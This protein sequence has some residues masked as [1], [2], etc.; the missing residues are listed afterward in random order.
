[1]AE[2]TAIPPEVTGA[3]VSRASAIR[4]D[5]ETYARLVR[6]RSGRT[7]FITR[8][9]RSIY[10]LR[11]STP[12]K[13][14]QSTITHLRDELTKYVDGFNDANRQIESHLED[15]E[16]SLM[17]D[18]D[19]IDEQL[20]R[21]AHLF[22]EV[23]RLQQR[24]HVWKTLSG[25]DATTNVLHDSA[26]K[27]SSLFRDLLCSFRAELL[28]LQ[29]TYCSVLE[30]PFIQDRIKH[31]T[32]EISAFTSMWTDAT[33]S[34]ATSSPATPVTTPSSSEPR[35]R[36][37][38]INVQIKKFKGNPLKW[39][40]Y[41][42]AIKSTLND[43]A[44]GFSECS[45][46]TIIQDSIAHPRAESIVDAKVHEG[47]SSEEIL[48][49][50][51]YEFGREQ[52][53]L[54][55]LVA[56]IFNVPQLAKSEASVL[57]FK[58][59]VLTPYVVLR[60][61]VDRDMDLVFPHIFQSYMTPNMRQMW[62]QY[63]DDKLERPTVD[64]LSKFLDTRFKWTRPSLQDAPS[65]SPAHPHQPPVQFK[66]SVTPPQKK[67]A[68]SNKCVLCDE[69]HW[70]G[71]CSAFAALPLDERNQLVRQKRLCLNCLTP[72]HAVKNC[73]NKHTCRHCGQKHHS[74]LHRGSQAPT[75]PPATSAVA[76]AAPTST[77]AQ[78]TPDL[79]TPQTSSPHTSFICSVMTRLEFQGAHTRA[80]LQMD[81][82][83]GMNFITED[84]ASLLKL[85]RYPQELSFTGVGLGTHRSTSY[86]L[87]PIHSCNSSFKTDPVRLSIVPK[88]VTTA[89]PANAKEV[90]ARA[91]QAGI[92]L[93]DP[94]LDG[95]VDLLVGGDYPWEFC[96]DSKV[97]A[98]YRFISTPFG[99][100]AVGPMLGSPVSLAT[101]AV[102]SS[103]S[104]DLSKLWTLDQVP[105]ASRLTADEQRA[106]SIFQDTTCWADGKVQVSLPFKAEPPTLGDSRAQALSRLLRNEQS[107]D[108]KG[109]LGPF[110]E[111]LREYITLG[112]A[113][114][115][116]SHELNPSNTTYYMPVHGVFK[117]A[118]T[119]TKVRPVFDASAPSKSGASLNDC[120]LVG[121]NLYPQ[122]AEVL[123]KFRTHPVGLSA[124]ISKM[125]REIRLDP[126]H[127]DFHR[128]LLRDVMGSIVDCR[129]ER[130]TFGVASS[131]FLA[132]QTLRFLADT[133]QTKYPRAAELIRTTFYVDD[134][135]SGAED[136]SDAVAVQHE[137]CNLLGENG[138]SL[139][140]WRSNNAQFVLDTPEHLRES[141][142]FT[143]SF[144]ESPKALG[145]HW[146]TSSDTLFVSTP[147]PPDKDSKVTKRSVASVSAAVFDVMGLFSPTTVLPRIILQ[148][149]WKLQLSWDA[150][151][152]P[153]LSIE[154][155]SWV[156]ELPLIGEHPIPRRFLNLEPDRIQS[157]SLHGFADASAKAYGAVVYLRALLVDGSAVTALVTAKARVL[158]LKH[159]SI[160]RAELVA[161]HLLSKLLA[162]TAQVLDVPSSSLFA[163]TD[164]AIVWHWPSKDSASIRDRFVANRV[165]ACHDLLTQV[166]WLHVPTADNPADIASRGMSAKD[167]LASSLWWSGPPWLTLAPAQW[168]VTTPSQPPSSR[169]V[170]ITAPNATMPSSQ[171]GFLNE[172]WTRFSSLH[173]LERVVAY[174]RRFAA[175]TRSHT[176]SEST[177]LMSDEISDSRHTLLRLAQLQ[178]LADVYSAVYAG[179]SLPKKH[180]LFGVQISIVRDVLHIA[181]RIRDEHSPTQPKFLILLPSNSHYT[182]L[183]LVTAHHTHHHPGVSALQAIIGDGYHVKGL[184]SALKKLSRQCPTCQRAYARTLSQQ[185]GLLPTS[186]TTPAPPFDTTGVD[187]AGPF[188]LRRGHTRKPVYEKCWVAVFVCTATKAVH[189]DVAASLS[190]NDFLATLSR[191][192]ARRGCPS[193][194]MSDNGSNF[195][196]ARESLNELV[197]HL[198]KEETRQG[199]INFTH[200]HGIKWQTSPPRA[201]H[202]GG[203]WEAA[204][205]QLKLLLHKNV[206]P[207]RLRFDEFYTILTELESILNSRPLYPPQIDQASPVEPLTPGHFLIG[208]PLRALPTPEQSKAEITTL[209]RWRLITQLK[210]NCWQQWLST[211]LQSIQ[212]RHKWKQSQNNIKV[213]D[214]VYIK[215]A[216]LGYRV[217]PLA[218]VLQTFP[219]DD[220]KVRAVKLLCKGKEFTRA[221]QSL[222]P[223][224]LPEGC[225]RISNAASASNL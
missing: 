91:T 10:A 120:L 126:S 149:A 131:P 169:P 201:P 105:E 72:S 164:S 144:K 111:A 76:A 205:K 75:S 124:D 142:S 173:K 27:G 178:G 174:I 136:L 84:I 171:S 18:S 200:R 51:A 140:K 42:Q 214:L 147:T 89:T 74:L 211:Y 195:R 44:A 119:T 172:L 69:S 198:N 209:R 24:L 134:F 197:A 213:N 183:F 215:D 28:E 216:T 113:H 52:V 79:S 110:N 151:L 153:D 108:R 112:H 123:L 46:I 210:N 57:Q 66:S 186:R 93:S 168:P 34:A 162:R 56:K 70:I 95:K 154:W 30:N 9:E 62:E 106:V 20:R 221:I 92:V 64:D 98:P 11:D 82:G 223:L 33:A 21:H 115:V 35:S 80:R 219:G 96:G 194:I 145:A 107:L 59:S 202:F 137:L 97:V 160:P 163:W 180:P 50:L 77:D 101:A 207:H 148:Q 47:A 161:A 83:S 55:L 129:M 188:W 132:T 187:F 22:G 116:P 2:E 12:D 157:L 121:P 225:A 73:N 104:D 54:P 86:V 25:M 192:V 181:T 43:R 53:V 31:L 38:P 170:L 17:K 143:L 5:D 190:T 45:K 71:R 85:P 218:K 16:A 103:L 156:E 81:H 41:N 6:K 63:V 40:S 26:D 3:R 37:N 133:F 135:V 212:D 87:L 182:C 114:V 78:V 177:S 175:N 199:I 15:D 208:R 158:P 127:R 14:V 166:R 217:W 19:N 138:M 122:L 189:V 141:S 65:P 185:M 8:T 191:F 4:P 29:R 184:R 159:T 36:M 60:K 90:V 49:A 220:G 155:H 204:V 99:Y 109:E 179:C 146:D 23:E 102:S 150:P 48:D 206:G 125:F 152:P 13:W 196:G 58:E 193:L 224:S 67:Q 165:Q 94:L 117:A 32:K 88:I 118:S 39:A 128:F 100:G 1:M 61:L 176:R 130:V 167:L 222:V 68:S 203:L 7:G 139:R